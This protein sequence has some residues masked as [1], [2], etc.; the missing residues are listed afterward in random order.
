MKASMKEKE[1]GTEACRD[2]ERLRQLGVWVYG[3]A[4]FVTAVCW[5]ETGRL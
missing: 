5:M 3:D 2:Q 1:S 4:L